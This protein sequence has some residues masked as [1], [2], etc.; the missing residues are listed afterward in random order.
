MAELTLIIEI[1]NLRYFSYSKLRVKIYIDTLQVGMAFRKR[2]INLFAR[3]CILEGCGLRV[4]IFL[5][6]L[7][8]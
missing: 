2:I 8:L 1:L 3:I 6:V 5:F 7:I 4:V